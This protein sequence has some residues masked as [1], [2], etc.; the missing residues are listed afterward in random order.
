LDGKRFQ[1][2]TTLAFLRTAP[3]LPALIL[4]DLNMPGM[5]GDLARHIQPPPKE[6]P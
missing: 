4:L 6:R 2:R 3:D 5:N 1:R